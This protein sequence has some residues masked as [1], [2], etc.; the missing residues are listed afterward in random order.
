MTTSVLELK[1]D[2]VRVKVPNWPLSCSGMGGLRT[3]LA[4]AGGGGGGGAWKVMGTLS[5]GVDRFPL[6]A[7]AVMVVFILTFAATL[8]GTW[9]SCGE[10]A[11]VKVEAGI[12]RGFGF[13]AV[14]RTVT[15]FASAGTDKSVTGFL[16]LAAV[17]VASKF[18]DCG[19]DEIVKDPFNGVKG[20]RDICSKGMGRLKVIAGALAVCPFGVPV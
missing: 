15:M 18:P 19:L 6:M 9:K 7:D 5:T 20:E 13:W 4:Q 12:V 2:P 1:P 16:R 3:G 10:D 8:N 14:F 11:E 17:I